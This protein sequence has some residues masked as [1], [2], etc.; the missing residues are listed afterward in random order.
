[1][2]EL[3]CAKAVSKSITGMEDDNAFVLISLRIISNKIQRLDE[4][5]GTTFCGRR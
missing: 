3:T 5:D 1:M 2:T 4:I